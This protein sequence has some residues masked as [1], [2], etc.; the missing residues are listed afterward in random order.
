MAEAK[1]QERELEEKIISI[2]RVAKV[3]KGGRRFSFSALVAVG[4]GRGQVG[5]GFGKANEVS[6]AIQKA[7]N[8]ARKDL[9]QVPLVGTTIPHERVGS[10]GAGLGVLKRAGAGTGVIDGG[11]A[12]GG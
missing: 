11:P 6:G 7:A 9:F 1:F 3:V 12:R 4:D 10:A 8:K 5:V 2:N